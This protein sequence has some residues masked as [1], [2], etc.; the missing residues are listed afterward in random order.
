[1]NMRL[2]CAATAALLGLAMSCG[3]AGEDVLAMVQKVTNQPAAVP[4]AFALFN[5]NGGKPDSQKINLFV[6]GEL[7][8]V[9]EFTQAGMTK[10]QWL[11]DKG[12]TETGYDFIADPD[13]LGPNR[14]QTFQGGGGVIH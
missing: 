7:I 2:Y 3:Q 13:K 8:P 10:E 4:G 5:G 12:Y 9:I 11:A 6:S 1:M 14:P